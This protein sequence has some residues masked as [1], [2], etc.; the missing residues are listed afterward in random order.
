MPKEK[1]E[2][3]YFMPTVLIVDDSEFMRKIL[4]KA[5]STNGFEIAGEAV[6]GQ[7]GIEK[8][9][10]LH[11]DIVTM[12]ITMPEKS[13]I[14]AI[15]EIIEYDKDAKIIVVSSMGQDEYIKDALVAG[16]RG[17]IVKPFTEESILEAMNK[18][19]WTG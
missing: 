10:E 8:Y 11:P 9:K 13:G 18:Q 19:K 1:N 12:D 6:N 2:R 15:Q 14:A 3:R 17:F 16:A 5:L 7:E 4:K